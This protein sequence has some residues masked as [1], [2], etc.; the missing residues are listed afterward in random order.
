MTA[1]RT[2]TRDLKKELS[3]LAEGI[4]ATGKRAL[5][6]EEVT[7]RL[8]KLAEQAEGMTDD[9]AREELK[10]SQRRWHLKI[11]EAQNERDAMQRRAEAAETDWQAAEQQIATLNKALDRIAKA[12]NWGDIDDAL[13]AIRV[14]PRCTC[15]APTYEG[16]PHHPS[17]P[18]AVRGE[19]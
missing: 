13:A 2:P 18:V 1:H 9:D 7:E 8:Q 10:E 4:T 11:I 19:R 6:L 12:I 14:A 16:E 5:S 3:E 15:S 17:C